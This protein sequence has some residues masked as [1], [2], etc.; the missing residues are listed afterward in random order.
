MLSTKTLSSSSDAA[1]YF[2]GTDNYYEK[3]SIEAKEQS[4][5]FGLGAKTLGLVGKVDSQQFNELLEGRL[6]SG[7]MLGV[8]KDGVR[9]HRPGFDLTFSVPKSVSIVG[10]VGEDQR[11]LS[12]IHKS[13]DK[14]LS[15]IQ[16]EAAQARVTLDGDTT[17]E[18]TENIVAAKFLHDL[19]R[20]CD[21]QLHV[22]TVVMNMTQRQDGKW[23]ALASQMGRYG[24]GAQK[25]VNGFIEQ[26][27]HHKKYYG[28]LFNAELALSLKNLGYEL[29]VDKTTGKFEIAGISSDSMTLFSQ[30]R[31]QI[32][33]MMKERGVSSAKAAALVTLYT[34][35]KKKEVDRQVIRKSW[36]DR[37]E[38]NGVSAFEE[39]KRAVAQS[40]NPQMKETSQRNVGHIDK[41][42]L[43]AVIE[44]FSRDRPA[45]TENQLMNTL[46]STQLDKFVSIDAAR[47][48]LVDQVKNHQLLQRENSQGESVYITRERV[49]KE[50]ALVIN[51]AIKREPLSEKRQLKLSNTAIQNIELKKSLVS[52]VKS[53]AIIHGV[54]INNHQQKQE[55]LI[56]LVK[57]SQAAGLQPIVLSSS[58]KSAQITEKHLRTQHGTLKQFFSDLTDNS[59]TMTISKFLFCMKN[60]TYQNFF[61]GHD[62]A[63]ILEDAQRLSIEEMHALMEVAQATDSKIIPLVN[64][65][66][67]RHWSQSAP[68][69]LLKKGGMSLASMPTEQGIKKEAASSASV[70]RLNAHTLEHIS[71]EKALEALA[72]H[73]I[74]FVRSNARASVVL[75]SPKLAKQFE[76]ISREQRLAQGYLSG[77]PISMT[78][79]VAKQLKPYAYAVSNS[80]QAGQVIRFNESYVSLG[81]RQ[82]E[83]FNI[84]ETF[85][86]KNQVILR[87]A[88]RQNKGIIIWNPNK[89]GGRKSGAIE[90]YDANKADVFLGEKLKIN[91]RIAHKKLVNG[92]TLTVTALHKNKITGLTESGKRIVLDTKN[93]EEQH[94]AYHYSESTYGPLPKKSD[95]LLVYHP[96]NSSLTAKNSLHSL[97]AQ[98]DKTV[99]CYTLDKIKLQQ[100]LAKDFPAS[101]HALNYLVKEEKDHTYLSL[102][103]N[104]LM[105]GLQLQLDDQQSHSVADEAIAYAMKHLAEREAAF[106]QK[107][108]LMVAIK[109][110]L[111]QASP[112][113]VNTALC[114]AEQSG[115]IVSGMS[116][117]DGKMWT[118]QAAIKQERELLD[119]AKAGLD[120][121]APIS[122][123][124]TIESYLNDSHLSDEQKIAIKTLCTN[125]NQIIPIQGLA[126][127]GKTTMMK[128]FVNFCHQQQHE[129]IVLAPTHAAVKELRANELKAQTLDAY[130]KTQS[131]PEDKLHSQSN[132]TFPI[133]ILD[134]ATMAATKR[135]LQLAQI[136][137]QRGGKFIPLGDVFQFS[138]I[139]SGKAHEQLQTLGLSVIKMTDIQRQR[140]QPELLSAVKSTYQ[141]NYTEAF[142]KLE[143]HFIEVGEEQIGNQVIDNQTLR[144]ETL[145]SN[146]LAKT[147]EERAQTLLITLSNNDRRMLNGKIR[148]GLI[149]EGSLAKESAEANVLIAKDFTQIELTR[150]SNYQVDDVILFGVS[151]RDLGVSKGEYLVIK[152]IDQGKNQLELTRKTGEKVLMKL[153]T[154]KQKKVLALSVYQAENREVRV[155]ELIRWTKSNT[156]LGLISPEL[157]MVKKIEKDKVLCHGV[158]ITKAGIQLSEK[159]LE[160]S[161]KKRQ[162]AHWDYAYAVTNYAAQGRSVSEVM[163]NLPSEHP[164][165]TTQRAF[166]V[167]LTRAVSNIQIYTDNKDKLLEHLMRHPGDK[168]SALEVTGEVKTL[169]RS[170]VVQDKNPEN[171]A[172]LEDKKNAGNVGDL[173]HVP[174]E[175]TARKFVS[176]DSQSLREEL[177]AQA[178]FMATAL[179]GEP[180][181]RQGNTLRFGTNKGSLVV[182]IHGD[183][184][185]LWHDFQTGQGGDMLGLFA[186]ERGL[187]QSQDYP[188][189]LKEAGAFIGADFKQLNNEIKQKNTLN[190]SRNNDKSDPKN[191]T[192]YQ[193][194]QVAKAN[195]LAKESQP[196]KGTIVETYLKK[197]RHIDLKK[198]PESIRFHPSV[199]CYK[200]KRAFPAMLLVGQNKQG[201]VQV[202]QAT[203]IDPKNQNKVKDLPVS[204]QT[205][206]VMSGAAVH[207]EL[208][209]NQ[210]NHSMD[211]IKTYLAE[212]VETGL[213]ALMAS[214]KD[215]VKVT[216]GQSNFLSADKLTLQKKVVFCFDHDVN[217][218]PENRLKETCSNLVSQGKTV[219]YIKPK[220]PGDDLNDVLKKEGISAVQKTLLDEKSFSTH[221]KNTTIRTKEL[222]HQVQKQS[223]RIQRVVQQ[224]TK[225][226]SESP[227]IKSLPEINRRSG[228]KELTR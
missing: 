84:V 110:V 224:V 220:T 204:K 201:N 45:F 121:L 115:H 134:E 162:Y 114:L 6:P 16:K 99:W 42:L 183:K 190:T 87:P 123:L 195:K 53:H 47:E 173:T 152:S 228:E 187:N 2:M 55:T 160:I 188:V 70:A 29:A 176:I 34:R 3:D 46:L 59:Q 41:G 30:R 73:D 118:T 4:A 212:G 164:L 163:V 105:A 203:F 93:I 217:K 168:T 138:S 50:Q 109:N 165:L 216:L 172:G 20:E 32:E 38:K 88:N 154:G 221:D 226:N 175:K 76:I 23:R 137:K 140:N 157:A 112:Q 184:Q 174:A 125:T 5:W 68:M 208:E 22:H 142:S 111:G 186:Q 36:Q 159:S 144:T 27:R 124:S 77:Q 69:E 129:V 211:A 49:E 12:A 150:A 210:K 62:G 189:L 44:S 67:M 11:V 222:T 130:L 132:G 40:L 151:Q 102:V 78:Q 197:H 207:L 85:D 100:Q 17:Y 107:D 122:T 179:L 25:E 147:P 94:L 145:A 126:G 170:S 39:A 91:R 31:E 119:I 141:L 28:M 182:T 193:K 161:L 74:N 60:Q 166:L 131:A 149:Q 215:A 54:E 181:D 202:A 108:L 21:P 101:Q 133:V 206:G 155:G 92:E 167:A 9:Q 213:S 61:N 171:T 153:P 177:N 43:Q 178:E 72:T 51:A 14:V 227:S 135:Q 35:Q 116:T 10:L 33:K 185:G 148:E 63:F 48:A 198:W 19:S 104:A 65:H 117:K 218:A 196:I 191:W 79:L 180:K 83:Y 156:Q 26:V 1:H 13:V 199:Y 192:D 56:P 96:G 209:K 97:L 139:E 143:K 82:G 103:K 89:V 214:P 57:L 158:S 223:E 169:D 75:S 7:Q 18:N 120:K 200:N 90:V 113:D 37:A 58:A 81:I 15:V 95:V 98:E 194:K 8:V 86:R 24:K 66:G 80:Y 225:E 128:A 219:D 205:I 64:R 127:V 71:E 52:V 136:V 146:Y 106:S